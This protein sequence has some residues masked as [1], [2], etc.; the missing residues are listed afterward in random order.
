MKNL[1]YLLLIF[2]FINPLFCFKLDLNATWHWQLQG[3]IDL[4]HKT[5][6]YIVDLFDTKE[7]IIKKL[8]N[9]NIVVIAYFSAGSF[10]PWREDSFKF[11]KS[12][13]GKKMQNWDERWLDIRDKRVYTI[14]KERIDLAKKKGFDGIEAD[15]VDGYINDTGFNLTYEDQLKFNILLALYAHKLGLK[16]ALKNNVEQIKDLY[17]YFDF[18]INESCNLYNECKKYE[19]F[20][21]SN[22]PVFNAEYQT[23]DFKTICK[24]SKKYKI[25]TKF[26]TKELN[27]EVLYECNAK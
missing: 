22:K 2:S 17:R 3:K 20:I 26:F 25:N 27:G 11:K 7:E 12:F 4:N 19:P 24:R 1:K 14:M 9:K 18:A 6:L 10:E 5:D 23:K 15:N 21:K 16:I 13:L 8:H